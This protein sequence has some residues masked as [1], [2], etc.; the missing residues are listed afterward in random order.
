MRLTYFTKLLT[1]YKINHTNF[2]NKIKKKK[3]IK[4]KTKKLAVHLA[5]C[6]TQNPE[7]PSLLIFFAPSHPKPRNP[8]PV[9]AAREREGGG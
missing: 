7:A 1:L 4:Y 2:T 5:I 6:S 8:K 9:G 3:K